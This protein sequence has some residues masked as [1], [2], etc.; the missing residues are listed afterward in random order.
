MKHNLVVH[1]YI[2]YE[3][4]QKMKSSTK[5]FFSKFDQIR[6]K[7]LMENFIFCAVEI[8]QNE[9]LIIG[10]R[11]R[12][13]GWIWVHNPKAKHLFRKWQFL[14][15][16]YYQLYIHS[17]G[18]TFKNVLVGPFSK[19]I[20]LRTYVLKTIVIFHR[21]L[22]KIWYILW[23]IY[24]LWYILWKIWCILWKIYIYYGIYYE[25]SGIC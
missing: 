17:F 25:R 22:W 21:I 4:A 13:S 2:G 18:A 6:M 5:D 10:S 8:A 15:H 12:S 24:I 7:S 9:D 1:L 19:N 16:G 20:A 11:S 23:K 3:V 14:S